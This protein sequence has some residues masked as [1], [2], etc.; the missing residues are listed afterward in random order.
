MKD[1]RG[2]QDLRA[3]LHYAL[4]SLD[5]VS[6]VIESRPAGMELVLTGRKIPPELFE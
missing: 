5:E 1:G 3:A 6:T 2:Q 4:V